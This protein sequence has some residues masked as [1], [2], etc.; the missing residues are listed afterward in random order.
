MLDD[1][2]LYPMHA[3]I[4]LEQIRITRPRPVLVVDHQRD[5]FVALNNGLVNHQLKKAFEGALERAYQ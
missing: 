4:P 5:I 1:L 3:S 2:R